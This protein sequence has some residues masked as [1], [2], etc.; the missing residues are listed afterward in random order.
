MLELTAHVR[1]RMEERGITVAD[2]ELA[3]RRAFGPPQP[4]SGPGKMAYVGP[5]SGGRRL[6]VVVSAADPNVVITAFWQS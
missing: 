6:K 3:I 2:L 4:A 5:A 1:E